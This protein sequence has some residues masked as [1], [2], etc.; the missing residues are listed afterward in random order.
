MDPLKYFVVFQQQIKESS[1]TADPVYRKG[2]CSPGNTN[3]ATGH[4][5]RRNLR[6]ESCM[7]LSQRPGSS[8]SADAS[9]YCQQV[10]M[11]VALLELLGENTHPW[12]RSAP[13]QWLWLDF[14]IPRD[15]SDGYQ[16]FLAWLLMG[17]ICSPPPTVATPLSIEG[18]SQQAAGGVRT[19]W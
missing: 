6:W 3:K 19:A 9:R 11:E 1:W 10:K 2:P 15:S 7:K 16:M 17:K 8:S 18:T 14:K 12:V 13:E 5:G 4:G